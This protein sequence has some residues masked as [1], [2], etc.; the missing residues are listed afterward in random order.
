MRSGVE[1][2]AGPQHEAKSAASLRLPRERG[3]RGSRACVDLAKAMEGIW[4]PGAGA[5][6]PSGVGGV[7]RSEGCRGNWRGPPRPRPCGGRERCL[8]ITGD[9]G[10]WPAAERESEGVVVVTTGGTTQPVSSEGPL[11]HR[12]TTEEGG[13]LMSAERS[14]RSVSETD[15]VDQVRALQRV[16]YRSA[17]QDPDTTVPRSLRQGRPQRHDVEGVGRRGHQPGRSRRRRRDHRR[18]RGRGRRGGAGVPR[19]TRR[20]V[21]GRYVSARGRCGGCTSRSRAQPGETRPLGIPAVR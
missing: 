18:D 6:G 20:G 12:C 11:L 10:K 21:A 1:Q 7:E 14:A 17:K 4:D 15:G 2:L 13:T 9:P 8:S 19:R 3:T 16:L 5:D